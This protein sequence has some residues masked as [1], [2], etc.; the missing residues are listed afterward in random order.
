MLYTNYNITVHC[1]PYRRPFLIVKA[2]LCYALA[3]GHSIFYFRVCF[4][5]IPQHK[6]FVKHNIFEINNTSA[7]RAWFLEIALV[8]VSVCVCV[9][10]CPCVRPRGH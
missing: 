6:I 3:N 7:A 10:V 1:Y 2:K 8:R 9:C 5:A 4:V